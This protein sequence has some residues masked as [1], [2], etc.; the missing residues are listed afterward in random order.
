MVK[1]IA[2][3][4]AAALLLGGCASTPQASEER[5]REAKA[6]G[7]HPATAAVYVYRPNVERDD[8]VLWINERLVGATL[9]RSYFVV[10]LEPGRHYLAGLAHD[11]GRM[12]LQTRPG[13]VVFVE[14]RVA[15]GQ[16]R[17][18]RVSPDLGQKTLLD[19]CAMMENWAPGQRPLLR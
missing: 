16:S 2:L 6:F 11:N 14:L 10:H 1:Q 5:D 15:D 3:T 4:I 18:M 8:S 12:A 19:C 7:T 17:F 9:S 13:E